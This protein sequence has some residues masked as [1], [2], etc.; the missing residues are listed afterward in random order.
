MAIAT[1]RIDSGRATWPASI[2][3]AVSLVAAPMLLV[4]G[5]IY[6]FQS[7]APTQLSG[8][9]GLIYVVGWMISLVGLWRLAAA[10]RS[11]GSVIL[12]IQIFGVFLAMIWAVITLV[13]R[14]PDQYAVYYQVVDTAWPASHLFMLVTGSAVVLAGSLRGWQRIAPGLCGLSIA[15]CGLVIGI[16]GSELAGRALFGLA[17]AGAFGLLALAVRGAWQPAEGPIESACPARR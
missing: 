11:V 12:G 15:L 1:A 16:T 8:L 2:F 14:A 5:I 17:T 4:E 9:L 3:P 6:R 7:E 13:D 10:G